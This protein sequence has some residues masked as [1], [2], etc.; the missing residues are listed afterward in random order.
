MIHH[1]HQ[2]Y[3]VSDCIIHW[4]S[5]FGRCCHYNRVTHTI[6]SCPLLGTAS[7]AFIE[8]DIFPVIL[9]YNRVRYDIIESIFPLFR[10]RTGGTANQPRGEWPHCSQI[11]AN[12]LSN[13]IWPRSDRRTVDICKFSHFIRGFG[14][15]DVRVHLYFMSVHIHCVPL[16]IFGNTYFLYSLRLYVQMTFEWNIL[17][18]FKSHESESSDSLAAFL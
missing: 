18:A 5:R 8:C 3:C 11:V 9:P 2:T 15:I 6:R 13:H 12:L 17:I 14:Q 1:R 10:E 4:H 16:H 7:T